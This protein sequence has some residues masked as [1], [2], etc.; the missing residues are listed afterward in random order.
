MQAL[1]LPHELCVLRQINLSRP[2][3]PFISH[4][5]VIDTALSLS[6]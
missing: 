5:K 4:I 1:P 2:Q 6:L 3:L